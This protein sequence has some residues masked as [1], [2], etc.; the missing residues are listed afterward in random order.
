MRLTL[1]RFTIAL[2]TL[3]LAFYFINKPKPNLESSAVAATNT[4]EKQLINEWLKGMQFKKPYTC[5]KTILDN[6]DSAEFN[7][8]IENDK[9]DVDNYFKAFEIFSLKDKFM[10]VRP[11]THSAEQ[12]C[13][14]ALFDNENKLL[15]YK[16]FQNEHSPLNTYGN[17]R[18]E[19][20]NKDGN[21][22]ILIHKNQTV[23]K[24]NLESNSTVQEVYDFTS[25][26]NTI[27]K[28]FDY[29]ISGEY[30]ASKDL[31][32]Y[33]SISH[34]Y[35]NR[36]SFENPDVIKII[37]RKMYEANPNIDEK[38]FDGNKDEYKNY[39]NYIATHPKDT[40]IVVYYQRDKVS[41]QYVERQ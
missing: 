15:N 22:E 41:K 10:M 33:P 27:I 39:L 9:E 5:Y 35:E 40:S 34:T 11:K 28:V 2:L 23:S 7:Q 3:S 21:E 18:L 29:P 20:W 6:L 36:I 38:E 31:S 12:G 19:D 24:Y 8:L 14:F 4:A 26:K 30:T 16:L 32:A 17:V 13:I 1:I 37:E 25:I